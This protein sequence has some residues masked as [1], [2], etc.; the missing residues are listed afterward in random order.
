[1]SRVIHVQR[2]FVLG[3]FVLDGFCPTPE[4]QIRDEVLCK[5]HSDYLIMP[6][7]VV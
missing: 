1:M 6:K 7:R 3:G 2:G 4:N 5:C